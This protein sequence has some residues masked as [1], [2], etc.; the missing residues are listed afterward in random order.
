M[1]TISSLFWDVALRNIPEEGRSHLHRG[2]SLKPQM[3]TSEAYNSTLAI[4]RL[5]FALCFSSVWIVD[6]DATA[7]MDVLSL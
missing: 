4:L 2:G 7:S 5:V 1:V 6:S 3:I